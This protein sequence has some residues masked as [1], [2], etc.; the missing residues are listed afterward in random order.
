MSFCF[1]N[2]KRTKNQGTENREKKREN[3]CEWANVRGGREREREQQKR[4]WKRSEKVFLPLSR[5]PL[6][7]V[8]I[9]PSLL[10]YLIPS[11]L[12]ND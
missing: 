3:M 1:D 12:K 5:L 9:V 6:K 11:W 7:D 10:C 2:F 8:E 4:E